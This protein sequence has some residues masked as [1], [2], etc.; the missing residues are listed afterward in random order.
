LGKLADFDSVCVVDT[1]EQNPLP[2]RM[3]TVRMA[4]N[5]GDYSL[6]GCQD[7]EISIEKKTVAELPGI[8]M[9]ERERFEREMRRIRNVRMRRLLIVGS[10]ADVEAGNYH[11]N[12]SPR[13]VLHN[14][15][16]LEVRYLIPV[17]WVPDPEV[18]RDR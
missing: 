6:F 13:S 16:A 15:N 18:R 3:K 5:C 11:S 14:L 2:I 4:L 1:R 12:I 8:T 10:K 7:D 9:G 17:V